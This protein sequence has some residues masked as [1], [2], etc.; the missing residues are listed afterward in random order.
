[1]APS[2]RCSSRRARWVWKIGSRRCARHRS[3]SPRD[4]SGAVVTSGTLRKAPPGR[5]VRQD[6]PSMT[7][8]ASGARAHRSSSTC[9]RQGCAVQRACDLELVGVQRGDGLRGQRVS[10]STPI[11]MA[12]SR[13]GRWPRQ[14]ARRR[15]GGAAR[16]DASGGGRAVDRLIEDV[17]HPGLR[18]RAMTRPAVMYAPP[19]CSLWRR[20]P[21]A[22]FRMSA[23]SRRKRARPL[24]RGRRFDLAP[25]R[26]C[27]GLAK[28]RQQCDS[29]TPIASAIQARF[30]MKPET[31]GIEWPP[32]CGKNAA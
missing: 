14:A 24:R 22:G 2:S 13:A 31:T 25:G 26:L 30:D 6:R 23:C 17:L 32:G 16:S 5:G 9:D 19:S 29:V 18:L 3:R 21:A 1:M 27:G 10:G 11:T 28:A 20:R 7:I 8:S 4:L 15:E 12:T